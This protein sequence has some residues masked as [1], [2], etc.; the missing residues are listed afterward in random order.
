MINK[1]PKLGGRPR[2]H[3]EETKT[4]SISTTEE[5][6]EGFL[7]KAKKLG[8]NSRSELCDLIGKDEFE[9]FPKNH[10]WEETCTQLEVHS[11]YELIKKIVDG[12]YLVI[13]N[14]IVGVFESDIPILRRL[15]PLFAQN[16]PH[17]RF[18]SFLWFVRR[19]ARS[20]GLITNT[21]EN[22]E[23]VQTVVLSSIF[24]VILR[25]YIFPDELITNIL[26]DTKLVA[27]YLLLK[28]A[29][30]ENKIKEKHIDFYIQEKVKKPLSNEILF[31]T[32]SKGGTVTLSDKAGSLELIYN[33]S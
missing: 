33:P 30:L 1:K 12:D 13:P 32:L 2:K 24:C 22:E 3:F 14:R 9:L 26:A 25:D 31:G 15:Y 7:E 5:G 8:I 27:F 6:W 11:P 18:L 20:L 21:Y 29:G 16:Y 19:M 28:N 4:H 17:P 23:L 10:E